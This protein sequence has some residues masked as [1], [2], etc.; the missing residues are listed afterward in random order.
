[1]E[2]PR[3]AGRSRGGSSLQRARSTGQGA[4]QEPARRHGAGTAVCGC[5]AWQE[6]MGV[7]W[8]PERVQP[9]AQR[10]TPV[11]H[12]GGSPTRGPVLH[13][14]TAVG[15]VSPIRSAQLRA[16]AVQGRAVALAVG[17]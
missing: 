1:M 16:E 5:A 4:A 3:G 6:P 8:A 13:R 15:A 10:G 9:R 2:L 11:T 12:T 7:G 14:G 17:H